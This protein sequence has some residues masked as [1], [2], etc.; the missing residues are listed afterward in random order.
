MPT[1]DADL[2]GGAALFE[3]TNLDLIE[4]ANLNLI[5]GA[6]VINLAAETGYVREGVK[7]ADQVRCGLVRESI[8]AEG[9]K[10]AHRQ[11]CGV[12]EWG[13]PDLK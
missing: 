8:T 7:S 13:R 9:R 4:G 2:I 5:E 11:S 3:G 12:G 10:S 6:K 1:R